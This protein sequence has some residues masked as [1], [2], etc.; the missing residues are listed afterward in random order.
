MVSSGKRATSTEVPAHPPASSAVKKEVS[1]PDICSAQSHKCTRKPASIRARARRTRLPHANARA[2]IL[3]ILKC[4]NLLVLWCTTRREVVVKLLGQHT[5]KQSRAAT[6]KA[7]QGHAHSP[8]LAPAS[9]GRTV[10][11]YVHLLFLSSVSKVQR[12]LSYVHVEKKTLLQGQK[13]KHCCLVFFEKSSF[14]LMVKPT[15]VT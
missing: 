9:A 4:D 8:T 10:P 6:G 12:L 2:S 5:H 7:R 13:K 3:E 11:P 14:R 15:A 1:L